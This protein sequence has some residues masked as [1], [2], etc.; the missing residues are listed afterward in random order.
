MEIVLVHRAG[1]VQSNGIAGNLTWPPTDPRAYAAQIANKILGGGAN[2]V[3]FMI[4]REQKSWTYGAYSSVNSLKNAGYFQGE[5]GSAHRSDGF[6]AGGN[7]G[8]AQAHDAEPVP[9][10]EFEQAGQERDDRSVSAV[11]RDGGPGGVTGGEGAKLLGLPADYVQT[12]LDRD[13]SAVTTAEMHTAAKAAIR[14]DQALIVVVGDGAKIYDKLKAIGPVRIVAPDG[15]PLTPADLAPGAVALD[16]DMSKSSPGCRQFHDFLSGQRV[17]LSNGESRTERRYLDLFRAHIHCHFRS[18]KHVGALYGNVSSAVRYP[19]RQA[20]TNGRED[21][22]DLP[23]TA[24]P[25]GA[26]PLRRP[27]AHPRRRSWTPIFRRARH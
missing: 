18:T 21:R 2:A 9:S 14:P 15:T 3:L 10:I 6:G 7:A 13:Y 12:S 26:R 27:P 25:R 16:L 17:R 11:H 8:T 20:G 5:F 23:P 22:R 1:S 24:T 19:D 4:L